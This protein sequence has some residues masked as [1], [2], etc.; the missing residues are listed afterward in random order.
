[1]G[2]LVTY[3]KGRLGNCIFRFLASRL[4]VIFYKYIPI[5]TM[6]DN[7]YQEIDDTIFKNICRY[8]LNNGS[9]P[10]RNTLNYDYLLFNGYYQNDFIYNF[11]KKEIVQYIKNNPDETIETD[12]NEIYYAKDIL[13]DKPK[14]DFEYKTI[15]HLRIEDYIELGLVMDPR[16]LE[17]V[18]EKCE[19]PFLF[20]HKP[21]SNEY[22]R[23]YIDFF[24]KKYISSKY[25]CEDVIQCYNLMRHAENLVCSKSTLSWVAALFNENNT[26][27]Y[28]PKNYGTIDHETFQ[29][30]NNNTEIYEWKTI[31]KDDLM[32][33]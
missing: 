2:F 1:M 24:K 14:I 25:Y 11:Y 33:L 30:P 5:K 18:L 17:P 13:G 12:R 9:L 21:I 7:Y 6:N 29:Y 8:L 20:V 31:S 15:I 28:M 26:K 27:V 19:Q 23:K 16:C 32:A 22:D 10:P 4:F 3:N